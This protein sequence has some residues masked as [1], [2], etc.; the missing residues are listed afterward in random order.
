M[1]IVKEFYCRAHGEFE[2]TTGRCPSGCAASIVQREIRTA[3]AY[4]RSGT[5]KFIDQQLS[6][7]AAENGLSDMRVDPRDGNSVMDREMRRR[8]LEK[9]AFE[10]K[11]G[12][13][14]PRLHWADVKH[15][16][17]GFSRNP[18]IAVPK[19]DASAFGTKPSAAADFYKSPPP[20][21][22][23]IFVGKPRD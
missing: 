19:V 9:Q 11:T 18:K 10:K 3:P 8:E 21:P 22:R 14:L 23:P 16:E 1:A 2:S 12:A 13:Q 7:I 5:L 6:L 20:P 15:A 17:A 4:R